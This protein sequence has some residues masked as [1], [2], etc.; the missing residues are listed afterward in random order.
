M[1]KALKCIDHVFSRKRNGVNTDL[2]SGSVNAALG[3]DLPANSTIG[4]YLYIRLTDIA[5]INVYRLFHNIYNKTKQRHVVISVAAMELPVT[6]TSDTWD[7]NAQ[8]SFRLVFTLNTEP[9]LSHWK[10]IKAA[11]EIPR[12]NIPLYVQGWDCR[13]LSVISVMSSIGRCCHWRCGLV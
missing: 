1:N 9:P 2:K 12:L 13:R 11:K 8:G 7:T 4:I 3:W 10:D 5:N 6:D